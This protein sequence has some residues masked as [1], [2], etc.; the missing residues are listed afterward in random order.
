MTAE[1]QDSDQKTEAPSQ[2]RLDDGRKRGQLVATRELATL[3]LFSVAALACVGLA[4]ASAAR[5]AAIGRALLA[6]AHRLRLDGD[7]TTT[8]L[9]WLLRETGAALVLPALALLAVPVVAAVLQNAVVWTS[10]PLQP[11]FERISPLAGVKRLFS[12][13]ALVELAKNLLKILTVGGALGYLLWPEGGAMIATSTLAAGPLLDYLADVVL[14]VLAVLAVLTALIAGLDYGWQWLD[15]MRKMRMTREEV[16][17]ELKQNEGDPHVRQRLR[18][19]RLERS[20][21]RMMADL[22]KATMVIVNPTHYAVA[23]RYVAG[24]TPAPRVLAKGVDAVALKIRTLAQEHR[25][26]V[27]ENPP[28]ARALHAACELGEF[29]PPAHYQAVAEIVSYVLRLDER[30][31]RAPNTHPSTHRP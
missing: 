25:I 7:G 14:R 2:Q 30:Q 23:L 29:I 20:R 11:K 19:L 16:R 26:P 31:Q 24:E 9:F 3:L 8:L 27:I 12:L 28:L 10:E 13:H 18:A 22:P 15:F 17:E 21:R 4:P 5:L 1:D 6:E